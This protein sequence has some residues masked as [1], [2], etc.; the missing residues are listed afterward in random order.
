MYGL[1]RITYDALKQKTGLG[2]ELKKVKKCRTF[3]D[4]QTGPLV[5]RIE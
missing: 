5:Q 1:D 4:N 2:G 3:G